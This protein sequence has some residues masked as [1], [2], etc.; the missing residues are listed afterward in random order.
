MP[1]L[2]RPARRKTQRAVYQQIRPALRNFFPVEYTKRNFKAAKI[3]ML[4]LSSSRL[5]LG[6]LILV[7]ALATAWTAER[8][9]ST[10]T[11]SSV[12]RN[13]TQVAD[14]KANRSSLV[15]TK[16]NPR[17]VGTASCAASACHGG[18]TKD[19]VK[20][21]EYTIWVGHDAHSKA[22]SVLRN[23]Q[24]EQIAHKLKLPK[25]AHESAVCLNCHSPATAATL[26]LN[27]D[28]NELTKETPATIPNREFPPFE[29]VG[30]E[31]CHGPAEH[32]LSAHVRPSW[33]QR[34]DKAQLGFQDLKDV[35]SRARSCVECHVGG[36]GRNVNHDFISA[37]HPRLFFELS[38]F[39]ANLP[40]HWR[41]E[42]DD[43]RHTFTAAETTKAE[44]A[45]TPSASFFE[46]KLWA[47][48]QVVTAERS[49]ELLS[50][51][52]TKA[53]A[54]PTAAWPEL[55][56]WNCYACHHDLQSASWRQ[57]LGNSN[58]KGGQFAMNSWAYSMLDI[59]SVDPGPAMEMDRL[60]K[61]FATP[62]PSALEIQKQTTS[63]A[64]VFRKWSEELNK[65]DAA[66][67]FLKPE[68]LD[69]LL[70][71][72]TGDAGQQRVADNWDSATQLYL[73]LNAL[74]ASARTSHDPN[75]AAWQARD[76][77]FNSAVDSMNETLNFPAGFHSP[78]TFA[79]QPIERLQ[80]EL[81]RLHKQLNP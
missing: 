23:E 13:V 14:A 74:H 4:S 43:A 10:P 66:K 58:R 16:S 8:E 20:G 22:Y 18:L 11:T 60:R 24:A 68:N 52:A 7:I 72:L 50:Q 49:L 32:W 31:Q 5:M 6:M 55:S 59:L 33:K 45:K 26:G 53:Q 77:E 46:A 41:R 36:E 69:R 79:V 15:E 56:E 65:P 80:G 1:S 2:S 67:E 71:H 70:N 35:L 39:H 54:N 47:I 48:G 21:A 78:R 51:R 61:L 3:F 37:G 40:A 29:G 9:V 81:K 25:P 27:S 17:L 42:A 64:I 12:R 75:N 62:S 34:T 63:L 38:G 30:C 28:T 73:A 44:P 57:T 76:R 19:A